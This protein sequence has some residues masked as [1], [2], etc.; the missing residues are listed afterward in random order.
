MGSS[1][2]T[3]KTLDVTFLCDIE[4]LIKKWKKSRKIIKKE[5]IE[6]NILLFQKRIL[7]HQI[8]LKVT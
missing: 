2:L 7:Y 3:T 5:V 8:W 1:V 4:E 6:T